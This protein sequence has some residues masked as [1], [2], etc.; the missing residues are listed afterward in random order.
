M[1]RLPS[2]RWRKLLS[3]LCVKQTKRQVGMDL[4]WQRYDGE[5]ASRGIGK[6]EVVAEVLKISQLEDDEE[7]TARQEHLLQIALER[8]YFEFPKKS[9]YDNWPKLLKFHLQR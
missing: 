2:L 9:V 8:G 5:G 6:R 1:H 4:T 3:R 7:L